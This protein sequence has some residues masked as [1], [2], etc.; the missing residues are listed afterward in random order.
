MKES[1]TYMVTAAVFRITS[2]IKG[3]F[4]FDYAA[5]ITVATVSAA[6]RSPLAHLHILCS[7]SLQL[8][9]SKY[10]DEAARLAEGRQ[11]NNEKE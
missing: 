8:K 6:L 7:T 11:H 9:K 4:E 2:V 5:G 3:K 1:A 10:L